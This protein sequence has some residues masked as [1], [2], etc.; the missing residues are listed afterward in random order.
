MYKKYLF[1]FLILYFN[2]EIIGKVENNQFVSLK[3]EQTNVRAGPSSDFPITINYKLQSIPMQILEEY[4]SWYKILDSDN[5]IG[6][7]K[8]HLI[9]KIRTVIVLEDTFLYSKY[10]KESYPIYKIEKNVILKFIKCKKN[11][12]KVFYNKKIIGW[13]NKDSIWGF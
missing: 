7:V 12:C 1:I 8:S 11:R 13:I 10:N 6:W 5:E 3:F 2:K 9:S 4:D